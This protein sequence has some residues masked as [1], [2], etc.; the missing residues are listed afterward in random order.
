MIHYAPAENLEHIDVALIDRAEHEIDM[1]AY[2]LTDW[3]VMQ[4]LTRAADR[5]VTVRVYLDRTQ[6]AEREPEKPSRDLPERPGVEIRTKHEPTAPMH[7]KC[8]QIDGGCCAQAPRPSSRIGRTTWRK[9]A[10]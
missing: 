8:Y 6:F 2:V 5:G 1:A 3:A 10:L 4:A 9:E 7:L